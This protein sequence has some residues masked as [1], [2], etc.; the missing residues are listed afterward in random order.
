MRA[1][2]VKFWK[3]VIATAFFC[4]AMASSP[5]YAATL[6]HRWTF[7]SDYTDAIGNADATLGGNGSV[8]LSNGK[9]I[10]AG[11]NGAGY[12]NLGAGVLGSGN[13]A[14]LELWATNITEA[15]NWAYLFTYGINDSDTINLITLC[16]RSSG[17][18]YSRTTRNGMLE[19]RVNNTQFIRQNEILIGMPES[20][21]YHYSVTFRVNGANTDTRWMVR[22]AATGFLLAEYSV[23]IPNLTLAG[24]ASAGW[25]LTLGHNPFTN[26]SLD[27]NAGFDEVRVWDGVLGD[28]QLMANA[29]AGPDAPLGGSEE[30]VAVNAGET[31]TVPTTGG[32]GYKTDKSVTLGTGAKIRFDTTDYFCKGLRFKAGGIVVPSGNVLDYVELSDSANY[33][34]TM[35]DANTIL[36]QLKS[37]IPY[38]STWS[39]GTPSTAADLDN[40][41][42]WTSVNAQGAAITAA[43]TAKTTVLLPAAA[44]ATFTLPSDASSSADAPPRRAGASPA[45]PT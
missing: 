43:P 42:N 24:A 35:E 38:E 30:A 12:L 33:E 40:V 13:A 1:M 4:V 3:H 16:N 29:I 10:L 18:S 39:G 21:A 14:T 20:M 32:Y 5:S 11:G 36:V 22:D 31:F 17:L 28:E 44:L 7:N 41:A 8:S 25:A 19:G 45:R 23:T 9:A 2:L 34:A 6:A 37:T 26:S 27:L 15:A